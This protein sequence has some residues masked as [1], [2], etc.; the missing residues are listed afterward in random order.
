MHYIISR[1]SGS[2]ENMPGIKAPD[3]DAIIATLL[4]QNLHPGIPVPL[5]VMH[6]YEI[7]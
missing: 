6:F 3:T 5:T 4:I 1:K 7:M 2:E